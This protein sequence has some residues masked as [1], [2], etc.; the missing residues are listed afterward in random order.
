M[1]DSKSNHQHFIGLIREHHNIIVRIAGY[2][3]SDPHRQE[4]LYQEIVY[5]L[6]SSFS[7]FRGEAKFS[8]WLYRVAVNTSISHL[9]KKNRR[10]VW[11]FWQD[12]HREPTADGKPDP[13]VHNEQKQLLYEHIA[14]LDELDRTL[15]LLYLEDLEYQTIAEITGLSP[16]NVGVRLHRIR[17]KLKTMIQQ[18]TASHGS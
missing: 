17:K 9:R 6:W 7:D 8:T 11:K 10:P 12:G 16:S 15:V 18:T 3:E 4:D 5:Q 13:L 14:E 1:S 2:Y